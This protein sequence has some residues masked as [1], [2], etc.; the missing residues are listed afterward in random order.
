MDGARKRECSRGYGRLWFPTHR[1][2]GR[3][4]DGARTVLSILER[5]VLSILDSKMLRRSLDRP[6]DEDLPVEP[7]DGARRQLNAAKAS[8]VSS[9]QRR[10]R[11]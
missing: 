11:V 5:I 2:K 3:A 1:A 7:R 6:T 8:G 10:Q 9:C 4:M